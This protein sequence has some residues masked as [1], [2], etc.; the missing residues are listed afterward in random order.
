MSTLSDQR[1]AKEKAAA[2]KPAPKKTK[3]SKK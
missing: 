2:E 1:E 3:S